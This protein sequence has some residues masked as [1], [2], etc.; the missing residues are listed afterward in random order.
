MSDGISMDSNSNF[1]ILSNKYK[2]SETERPTPVQERQMF[3]KT[4]KYIYDFSNIAKFGLGNMY[5]IVFLNVK[6]YVGFVFE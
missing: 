5:M 3:M 2:H 1:S 6:K 4:E